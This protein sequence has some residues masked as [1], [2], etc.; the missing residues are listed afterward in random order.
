MPAQRDQQAPESERFLRSV[1]DSLDAGLCILSADGTILGTNASWGVVAAALGL[2]VDSDGSP[3]VVGGGQNLYE[4]CGGEGDESVLGG[5]LTGIRGVSHGDAAAFDVDYGR[6]DDGERCWHVR[7]RPVRGHDQARVVVAFIDITAR[8]SAER[9]LLR[10]TEETSRLA[11]VARYTDSMVMICGP[12]GR[13]EWVNDAFIRRT[14]FPAEEVVGRLRTDLVSGPFIR[15]EDFRR[16]ADDLANGRAVD[17]EFVTRTREGRPYWTELHVRP[18]VED[19]RVVRMIGV[20]HDITDR[21]QAEERA[22]AA[23][24]REESLTLA[25]KHEKRLLT[26]V[27]STIPHGVWWK[28]PDLRFVGGNQAYL[29][30]RGLASQADLVGRLAEQLPS[31]NDVET[32]IGELERAVLET[33]EPSGDVHLDTPAS[34]GR[35][36]R[37]LVRVMPHRGVNRELMGIIGVGTDVTHLT[38]LERQLAQANRLESI[39]QLAA[40]IAHEINTPVQFVS[41]NTRFVADSFA[42]VLPV[43]QQIGRWMNGEAAPEED[44]AGRLKEL[45]GSADLDF[46]TAE[47]PSALD[48]S[49]EG[50]VRVTEI[51]RAMKDFSHPGHGRVVTDLNRAVESTVHVSRSEWKYVADLELE[52]DPDV[53]EIPCYEGELKQALLNIVVNAAQ[54]IAEQ[55]EADQAAGKPPEPL[56]R[57]RLSTQ[58]LGEH[59]RIVIADDGPGMP[60]E[61]RDRVY[62][63]FFTTK[64]VGKG[65]G[66]GL[67]LAHAVV[68]Q[69]HHGTIELESAPGLGTTFTITLPAPTR[70]LIEENES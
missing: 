45:V 35:I 62:D 29:D 46:I 42:S 11:T 12:D 50:L 49:I 61:V 26:T 23:L 3:S 56:G 34:G 51:V 5:V 44:L 27:L 60:P 6:P 24:R 19:G 58:R 14:G 54:A 15:S 69:K 70:P 36:R 39:G 63:P 41:D 22:K 2:I 18:I 37:A 47:I 7:V 25:L 53:G 17:R 67:S 30:Q 64:A 1:L 10:V 52:L 31:H 48:Q 57:I 33:G 55:R 16:L 8:K 40:G 65:T 20:E 68:V 4:A 32:A 66:Q 38:E 9:D 13:I 21:R 28:G 59:V 43:L